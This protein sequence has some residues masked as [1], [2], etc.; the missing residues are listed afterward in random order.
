MLTQ[1]PCGDS[2]EKETPS[3]NA[4][5]LRTLID[6]TKKRSKYGL[7]NYPSVIFERNKANFAVIVGYYGEKFNAVAAK[8]N[9]GK[10][11]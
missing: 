7:W 6:F 2:A 1:S 9:H 8:K 4:I 3:G 11:N 5:C 10:T